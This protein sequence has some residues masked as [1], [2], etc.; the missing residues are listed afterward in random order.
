MLAAERSVGTGFRTVPAPSLWVAEFREVVAVSATVGIAWLILML[1]APFGERRLLLSGV[2]VAP[3]FFG[4][5]ALIVTVLP[6]F[7]RYLA[8]TALLLVPICVLGAMLFISV[9]PD[10]GA[11]KLFNLLIVTIIAVPLLSNAARHAGVETVAKT[12]VFIMSVLLAGA[13]LFKLR[14]GFFDRQ[15]LF[16]MNGP[17]VFGRLMGI[18][19][20]LSL[21]AL[22]GMSRYVAFAVFALAV[23]WTMSKG[24]LLALMIATFVSAFW[25]LKGSERWWF[26]ASILSAAIVIVA[27][28]WDTIASF[29]WGRLVVLWDLLTKGFQYASADPQSLGARYIVYL[30]TIEQIF[31]QPLGAGLGSW[32]ASIP[33]SFALDYPHN[34][35]LELWSECGL[36]L[37]TIGLIPFV[38]FLA[39]GHPALRGAGLFLLM[40][41]MVSGDL[42]DARYLLCFSLLAYLQYQQR[43]EEN[44]N[45]SPSPAPL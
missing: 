36:V 25:L 43:T 34:L 29:D 31:S 16:F 12:I 5:A 38:L 13:I 23:L 42:L 9:R 18:A 30:T 22:R 19:A 2:P 39:P 44:T 17:I 4:M 33:E 7:R 24:P 26:I 15:V 10:Y 14:Y 1:E 41:Q 8:P 32:S 40:A 37:G 35:L 11:S 3:F 27:F 28:A 6:G 21:L 20:I 45:G